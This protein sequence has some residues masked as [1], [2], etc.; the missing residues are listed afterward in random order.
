MP[1]HKSAIK[2]IKTNEK[3]QQYNRHYKSIMKSS[4][5]KVLNSKEKDVALEQYK[6]TQSIL[7]KLA[8]KNVIHAN[9]AANQKKILTKHLNSLK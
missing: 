8:Q 3:S 7:D 4:V 1:N 2:R 5:K 6:Q 9:K